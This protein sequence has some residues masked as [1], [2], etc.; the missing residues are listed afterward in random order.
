MKP[1]TW[2]ERRFLKKVH[3]RRA[4]GMTIERIAQDLNKPLST[5][6]REVRL[7]G[8]EF[9]DDGLRPMRSPELD[10]VG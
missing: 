2:P 10:P 3:R 4:K 9:A 1:L 5:F 8:Y 7:L 6:Y